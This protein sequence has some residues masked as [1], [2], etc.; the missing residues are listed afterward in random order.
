MISN[1]KAHQN[2]VPS[3][4]ASHRHRHVADCSAETIDPPDLV[5][6][7]PAHVKSVVD[8]LSAIVAVSR[9]AAQP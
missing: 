1:T 4:W 6:L 3:A 5:P 2:P 7:R 9:P 8:P